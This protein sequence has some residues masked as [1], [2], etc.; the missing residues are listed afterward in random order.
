MPI[1]IFGSYL[2]VH[3]NM[4]CTQITRPIVIRPQG[5]LERNN[6][7]KL[8]ECLADILRGYPAICV[9]DM[10]HIDFID[11]LGLFCLVEGLLAARQQNWKMVI[12]NLQSPV[13]MVVEIARLDTVLE[14]FASLEFLIA[15]WHNVKNPG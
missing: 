10:T 12:S 15:H 5:C 9:V 7:S 2:N 3:A 8:L 1:Q 13:K 14:I 11:S 6:T 4:I